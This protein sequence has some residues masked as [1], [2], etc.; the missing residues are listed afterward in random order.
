MLK[1]FYKWFLLLFIGATLACNAQV[2]ASDSLPEE[3][4]LFQKA[5]SLVDSADFKEAVSLLKKAVKIRGNYWEAYNLMGR[6]KIMLK[7]HKGAE[8]DLNKANT[9]APLN[10]ETVK[11]MG[12][13]YF[14]IGK[15]NESKAALDTAVYFAKE[16]KI[17]DAEMIY[18]RALLMQKGKNYKGALE[19]CE[20][21][22]ELNPNYT[23]VYLLQAEM[24]YQRKEHNYVIKEL[25]NAIR[26]LEKNGKPPDSR[27]Y[28]TLAKSKFEMHDYKGAL[29]AWNTYITEHEKEEEALILRAVVKIELNDNTGAIVDLDAAI[30]VNSKNPVSYCYRGVAKAGNRQNIEALKD[31]D[32]SISL[33]FDY[34]AA[35]VNRAAVKF[36]SK[37]KR[38][39]CEDLQKAD[40]LGDDMAIKLY[41]Q[42]CKYAD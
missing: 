16:E 40:S 32:Y 15:Y 27:L 21:A 30:K 12:I 24:R 10:F 22:L 5:R 20:G 42:Y 14:L 18:Y 41:E 11:W 4:R 26:L 31:L 36:A 13:N 17:D 34:A 23:D 2:V 25:T 39:A 29:A 33:K 7:D 9:I 38:G 37:D 3:E 35:Y 1:S 6:S 19:A 8:S 28:K